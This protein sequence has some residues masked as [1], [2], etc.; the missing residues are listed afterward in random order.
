MRQIRLSSVLALAAVLVVLGVLP[1]VRPAAAQSSGTTITSAVLS[2]NQQYSP[3]LDNPVPSTTVRVHRI[4]T[5]WVEPDV[6]WESFNGGFDPTVEGSFEADSVG[7][8][9]VTLTALVQAWVDN[10]AQNYGLLLE[11][12]G[13]PYNNYTSSEGDPAANRPKLDVCYRRGTGP[14]VCL[15]IQ[16]GVGTSVVNDAYIW[17]GVPDYAGGESTVLFTGLFS[18]QLGS[19]EKYSLFRFELRTPTAVQMQSLSARSSVSP[20]LALIGV[21]LVSAAG[22]L[23][24]RRRREQ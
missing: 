4:I 22:V 5:P 8:H 21:G 17:A 11:Q 9:T 7:W 1:I 24:L 23:V 18:N 13:T 19:G 2:I 15:T 10:P 16:R 3:N 6:T 20:D 14:E 12:G